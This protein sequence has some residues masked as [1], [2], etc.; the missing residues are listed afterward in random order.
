[1]GPGG[2]HTPGGLEYFEGPHAVPL[3]VIGAV[4]FAFAVS[5]VIIIGNALLL[6]SFRRFKRLRTPSN[7][8]LCSLAASDM[9][10]GLALPVGIYVRLTDTGPCLFVYC[11]FISLCSTS[12]VSR[13]TTIMLMYPVESCEKPDA[14]AYFRSEKPQSLGFGC[15]S[16]TISLRNGGN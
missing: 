1:M 15:P 16:R 11:L 5:P 6:A 4:V 9:G 13:L 2:N 12:V 3:A 10:V 14:D 8:L 7:Y